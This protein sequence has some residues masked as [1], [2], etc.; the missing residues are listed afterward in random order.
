MLSKLFNSVVIHEKVVHSAAAV[1]IATPKNCNL[2]ADLLTNG[3]GTFFPG[4]R[5]ERPAV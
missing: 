3:A 2:D 5:F 4:T 1:S